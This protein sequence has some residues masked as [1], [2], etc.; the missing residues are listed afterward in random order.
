VG[1]L[2]FALSGG[3]VSLCTWEVARR[4]AN[5]C[6]LFVCG[7]R[8][9][10]SAA[11]QECEGVHFIG[12][13]LGADQLLAQAAEWLNLSSKRRH[14]NF[15]SHFYRKIFA[16]RAARTMRPR[17]CSVLYILNLAQMV[18]IIRRAYPY[19]RIVLH[20]ERDWL[21]GLD[22]EVVDGELSGADAIVVAATISL[23]RS[24]GAFPINH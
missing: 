12:L 8:Q 9:K 20:M 14:P 17:R 13:A 2:H 23:T 18:P 4:L 10:D 1:P 21:A 3:A 22:R 24:E 16:Q 15:A 6:D 11:V 7:P 19:S 5:S